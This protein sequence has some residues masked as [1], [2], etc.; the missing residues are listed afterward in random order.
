MLSLVIKLRSYCIHRYKAFHGFGQANFTDG[1]SILGLIQFTLLP[2]LPPKIL[3]DLKLVIM[4]NLPLA[5]G[6]NHKSM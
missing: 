2:Q 4:L 6:F 1:G 5:S 3:L